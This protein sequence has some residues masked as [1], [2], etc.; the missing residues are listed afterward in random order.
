[1][2]GEA[3]GPIV[4]ELR[5]LRGDLQA[6]GRRMEANEIAA[7]KALS[8]ATA[9]ANA[10]ERAYEQATAAMRATSDIK[11]DVD[12]TKAAMV[13]HAATVTQASEAMVK[14]NA[15]QTPILESILQLAQAIKKYGPRLIALV[16]FVAVVLGTF[17]GQLVNAYVR[18]RGGH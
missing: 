6:M 16:A 3:D 17:V 14:A 7:E 9:A 5:G 4:S 12:D 8:V 10:A 11:T 13:R 15:D 1:V 18:A 2:N